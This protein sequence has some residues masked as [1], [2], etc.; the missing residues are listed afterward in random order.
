MLENYLISVT[1]AEGVTQNYAISSE[2][3]ESL[4]IKGKAGSK[5]NIVNSD[6]SAN[7]AHTENPGGKLKKSTLKVKKSN[8]D[9]L[10]TSEDDV[11]Q[12]KIEN[13][14][15]EPNVSI[16]GDALDIIAQGSGLVSDASGNF[17]VEQLQ[18]ASLAIATAPVVASNTLMYGAAGVGALAAAAGGGGGGGSSNIDKTPPSAPALVLSTGL[19]N[20]ATAAKALQSAGVVS[21]TAEAGSIIKVTFTDKNG[22][23]IVKTL[24]GTGTPQAVTLL[25]ADIG[26]SATQL[27]DGVISIK[28]IATDAAG[29]T[30]NEGTSTFTLDTASPKLSATVQPSISKSTLTGAQAGVDETITLTLTLDSAVDGLTSGTNSG[31]FKVGGTAVSAT[32]SG[33][34]GS[35]TRTL[36]YK[37]LTGQNGQAIIDEEAL[38]AALVGGLKDGAGNAFDGTVAI[39]DIDVGNNVLPIVKTQGP[40]VPTLTL[41]ANVSD[42]ATAEEAKQTTG[43]VLV[44]GEVGSTIE[45][46]FKDKDNHSVVKRVTGT[47]ANQA[48]V[49]EVTDLSASGGP[50]VD[51]DISVTAVATDRAGNRGD[52]SGISILSLDTSKPTATFTT[53]A[54]GNQ[55]A[56]VAGDLVMTF[57][58]TVRGKGTGNIRIYKLID[59]S[60]PVSTID[61]S[62]A[63]I[64]GSGVNT[65]VIVAYNGL[66]ANTRYYV[67]IDAGA[68]EDQAGNA[69]AGT[70]SVGSN[71]WDFT[72]LVA[73]VTMDKVTGDGLV[74]IDEQSATITLRGNISLVDSSKLADYSAAGITVKL[75]PIDGGP[76][77]IAS[78]IT[79]N[80]GSWSATIAANSLTDGKSYDATVIATPTIAGTGAGEL[81]TTQNISVDTLAPTAPTLTLANG[82][83]TGATAAEAT[84]QSG[85]LTVKGEAGSN[86]VLTFT[87]INGNGVSRS[88]R[89]DGSLQA[90]TLSATELVGG[91]TATARKLADGKV[92]VTATA[93]DVAGNISDIGGTNFDLDTQAPAAPL[94]VLG[95]GSDTG[96]SPN[97]G[98]TKTLRPTLTGTSEAKAT[99]NIYDLANNSGAV[100]ATVIADAT[101]G[102][103]SASLATD[104]TQGVHHL[105]AVATD[106]AGNVSSP[107][108]TNGKLFARSVG[109]DDT[110]QG[111]ADLTDKIG[112]TVSGQ[113]NRT[114]T[115]VGVT[116][117]NDKGDFVSHDVYYTSEVTTTSASKS[118]ELATKLNT[119]VSSALVG[120]KVIIT[121]NND[122]VTSLSTDARAALKNI[123]GQEFILNNA[124]YRSSY[125]LITQKTSTTDWKADY[126]NYHPNAANTVLT[127]Y[128]DDNIQ[129]VNIDNATPDQPI[130]A[131]GSNVSDGA[132]STEA[133]QDSGVVTVKAE[134]GSKIK[135]TFTNGNNSVVKEILSTGVV[136]GVKLLSSEVTTLLGGTTPSAA[137]VSVSAIATD[138]A[139]NDSTAGTSSFNLDT[140]APKLSSTTPTI[141]KS[142]ILGTGGDSPGETIKLTLNFDSLV[143]GLTSGTVGNIFKVGTSL[144]NATWGGVD[145][146]NTR[147]LTYTV[148]AGQNGEVTIDAGTLTAALKAGLKDVSGNA[149]EDNRTVTFTTG[150]L[151]VVDTLR[152]GSLSASLAEDTGRKYPPN[153]GVTSKPTLNV[154]NSEQTAKWFYKVGDAGTWTQGTGSSFNLS[155][156]FNNYYLKQ[157]DAA[158]NESIETSVRYLLDTRRPVITSEHTIISTTNDL[159]V[160]YDRPLKMT[161]VGGSVLRASRFDWLDLK[162]AAEN[163]TAYFV[164]TTDDSGVD[165][166]QISTLQS[167]A[168]L[169]N[170]IDTARMA[171]IELTRGDTKQLYLGNLKSGMYSLVFVDVAGNTS[172]A[173]ND[174]S[175]L[176]RLY[177]GSAKNNGNLSTAADEEKPLDRNF[178]DLGL[179][180]LMSPIKYADNFYFIAQTRLDHN[181]LDRVFNNGLDTN[182]SERPDGGSG[183]VLRNDDFAFSQVLR[184]GNTYTLLD[185]TELKNLLAQQNAKD[186]WQLQ[187]KKD[188][189]TAQFWTAES[190]GSEK[191]LFYD[192]ANATNSS[193]VDTDL[194]W[195]VFKVL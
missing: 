111:G 63:T 188:D 68:F 128:G 79:Y 107:V 54:D 181:V 69:Y 36:T 169:A 115:G 104:L 45:V 21:V 27:G 165:D 31:V 174:Y 163:V 32:W 102:A 93:T 180:L 103:W 19:S 118:A 44:N 1:S 149:F 189:S 97:D 50:L 59:D 49:L 160:S 171:S 47:G 141:D 41:G 162:S 184:D 11:S 119:I 26:T 127:A 187:A 192:Y 132:T 75:K 194:K 143:K 110:N 172:H 56:S 35:A 57:N 99:I 95:S 34:A 166:V 60:A 101:T 92:F 15:T 78:G 182:I 66:Q 177:I 83:S 17:V 161:N 156:G 105:Y 29:N 193:G 13:F 12:I 112:V 51:G 40:S 185:K 28:A 126:E 175:D 168:F 74:N 134:A 81:T 88:F 43:V 76:D 139:G 129:T 152:P 135:L 106:L 30:S 80:Q 154:S 173:A 48:V 10:L 82:V 87:D 145:S 159:A 153:D 67:V 133:T 71:G 58:E 109:F 24:T 65:K 142:I 7:A 121:T 122:W 123:G 64:T 33:A 164:R 52:A 72:T 120:Y 85:V 147:T 89:A 3:K 136:Q 38:K 55:G 16:S 170:N 195:A 73:S 23:T 186:A 37:V 18:T 114:T 98:Q 167:D 6:P 176:P 62:N 183:S 157:Q 117:I 86:I 4:T 5:Y 84:Q 14:Y 39:A 70:T 20:G 113:F 108:A 190:A 46:T 155:E 77:I 178:N 96:T 146:S 191:H 125:L 140:E 22:H 8:N 158:G 138:A 116:V 148:A 179:G 53:P 131:L 151:P 91:L 100:L 144:A 42:G 124:A 150:A 2:S 25:S 130:L 90:I 61:A 94:M 137:T 9:L